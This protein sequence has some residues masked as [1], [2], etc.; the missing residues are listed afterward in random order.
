MENQ[1]RDFSGEAGLQVAPNFFSSAVPVGQKYQRCALG[2]AYSRQAGRLLRSR[3]V[4]KRIKRQFV[5]LAWNAG[6]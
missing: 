2:P 4:N 6:G 3:L 5:R 1:V